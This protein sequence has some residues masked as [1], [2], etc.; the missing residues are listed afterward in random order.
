M[1][2]KFLFIGIIICFLIFIKNAHATTISDCSNLAT[3]GSTYTLTS[4]VSNVG[5]GVCMN[6]TNSNIILD[7]A[8]NYIY[9]QQGGGSSYGINIS[10]STTNDTVM[11]CNVTNWAYGVFISSSTN[12]TNITLN[13]FKN[14]NASGSGTG[15]RMGGSSLFGNNFTNNTFIN[16]GRGIDIETASTNNYYNNT[17]LNNTYAVY[18]ASSSNNGNFFNNT[19]AYNNVSFY[20]VVPGPFTFAYNTFTEL[21]NYPFGQTALYIGQPSDT[22]TNYKQIMNETNVINGLPILFRGSNQNPCINN[23]VWTNGSSYGYMGFVGCNNITVTSTS[24]LDG[25]FFA[26]VY[27]SVISNVNISY[28]YEPIELYATNNTTVS[29]GIFDFNA[30]PGIFIYNYNNNTNVINSDISHNNNSGVIIQSTASVGYTQYNLSF[31]NNTINDNSWNNAAGVYINN[32][33]SNITLLNNTINFNSYSFGS[34]G[35][36]GGIYS[37]ATS[38]QIYAYNNT[39]YT[40]TFGVQL[41]SSALPWFNLTGG[42]IFSSLFADYYLNNQGNAN[43]FTNTNFTSNRTIKLQTI[44]DQFNYANDTS[45][46]WMGTNNIANH[47]L[48]RS[49]NNWNYTNMTWSDWD[50][51]T[52]TAN[53]T[54]KGLLT[55]ALYNVSNFSMSYYTL[56]TN[57]SG[58][59][60]FSI[61]LNSTSRLIS[62]F[63][64]T[65]T[66]PPTYSNNNTNLKSAGYNITHNLTFADNVGISG[67]IF[68]FDNGTGTMVNDSWVNTNNLTS[69]IAS[70]T[71]LVTST[72]GA[73]VQ[74]CYYANDTS[75]N[76]NR[77]SCNN[78]FTYITDSS[79]AVYQ[80]TQ[81]STNNTVYMLGNSFTNLTT[82]IACMNITAFNATLNC[83]GYNINGTTG[84]TTYGIYANWTSSTKQNITVQNCNVSNWYYNIYG[85]YSNNDTIANN[86][87]LGNGAGGDIVLTSCSNTRITNNTAIGDSNGAGIE[88]SNGGSSNNYVLNNTFSSDE[89]GVYLISV[90]SGANNSFINDSVYSS[91]SYDYYLN[92]AGAANNFTNTNFT[93]SAPRVI[94]LVQTSD[95]FNYAND[96]SGLWLETNN[97]AS[98]TF[99]RNLIYWSN[100]FISWNETDTGTDTAN[101][102]LIGL[103]PNTNY[104]VY[105][106]TGFIF[107][108][109]SLSYT[110]NSGP[111]GTINFTIPLTTTR[112]TIQVGETAVSQCANIFQNNSAYYLTSSFT[113]TTAAYCLNITGFNDTIDCQ[114][115]TITGS[116][117]NNGI[118]EYWP[119]GAHYQNNTIKNCNVNTWSFGFS[120]NYA[121]NTTLINNTANFNAGHAF[122]CSNGN[123]NTYINNTANYNSASGYGMDFT[124]SPNNT[125]INNTASGEGWGITFTLSSSNNEILINNTIC[126][127]TSIGLWLWSG[128]NISVT[129]GSIFNNTLDY[130]MQS[131][132]NTNI[133]NTN[134]T[135]QRSIKFSATTDYF[136][137]ANDTSSLRLNTSNINAHTLNRTLYSWSQIN[138]SWNDTDSGTDAAANYT[139]YG[140]MPNA[141][142]GVYNFSILY[143]TI[144]ASSLGMINFN[145]SLNTTP[146][147]IQVN[148]TTPQ[149]TY[150]FNSTNSTLA[151]TPIN[152]SLYWNSSYGL[153]GYIFQFCNGTWNGTNCLSNSCQYNMTLNDTNNGNVG[154]A[155][156]DPSNPNYN[157]GKATSLGV[158]VFPRF[159][160][161]L[162]NLSGI[163]AGAIITNAN[164]SITAANGGNAN[165]GLAVY[166]TSLYNAS[167]NG[168]W[169]EGTLNGVSCGSMCDLTQNI[170]MNNQP[171]NTMTLQYN[172]TVVNIIAGSVEWLNVTNSTIV[173]FANATN[174]NMSLAINYTGAGGWSFYS[175]EW[176]TA[177]QRPQ[178]VVTYY[179]P[180]ICGWVND[181]WKSMTGTGNWSNVTKIVNS[182][183]GAN[184]AWCEY[185]NNTYNVW[186]STSCNV[187]SGVSPF[188]YTTTSVTIFTCGTPANN[189]P[190][191]TQTINYNALQQQIQ[192]IMRLSFQSI[193]LRTLLQRMGM[194]FRNIINILNFN[195]IAQ[196]VGIVIKTITQQIN[197]NTMIYSLRTAVE[198]ISQSISLNSMVNKIYSTARNA[199]QQ[200]TF[201]A[202][203]MRVAAAV[204]VKNAFQSININS[205]ASRAYTAFIKIPQIL[206]INTALSKMLNL[207]RNIGQSIN[208]NTMISKFRILTATVYGT[209]TQSINFNTMVGK[210][211]TAVRNVGQPITFGAF[212]QKTGGKAASPSQSITFNTMVNRLVYEMKNVGQAITFNTMVSRFR[213]LSAS[214]YGTIT[215]SIK[216]NTM[217]QRVLIGIRN[218]GQAI[219]FNTMVRY[220]VY[221]VRNGAQSI[222]LNTMVNRLVYEMKNVGQSLTFSTMMNRMLV[223][224]RNIPQSIMFNTMVNRLVYEIRNA[225]QSIKFSTM[226]GRLRT[227]FEYG[228]QS[229]MFNSMASRMLYA[230][231]NAG[232]SITFNTMVS[233]FRI[234]SASV[235][236]TISQ[237]ITFNTMAGRVRT[238]FRYAS[239]NIIF[240]TMMKYGLSAVRNVGQPITFGAFGGKAGGKTTS[241]SQSLTFNTMVNR[242]SF[243]FKY[244]PQSLTFNT[245]VNRFRILSTST[246]GG[247]SQRININTMVNRFRN[248]LTYASQSIKLN[249]MVNKLLMAV[250]NGAQSITF[251]TM[252]NRLSAESRNVG[253]AINFNT[254]AKRVLS[255]FRYV[256]Q[257]ITFNTMMSR[258]RILLA[259]NYG[260]IAQSIKINTMVGRL[261][262]TFGLA[263]QSITFNSMVSRMLSMGRNV[264]Q[265]ITFFSLGQKILPRLV[266]ATQQI[267]INT[268]V[269]RVLMGV[270]IGGQSI[271]FNTMFGTFFKYIRIATQQI[272]FATMIKR[273]LLSIIN[274]PQSITFNTMV[275]RLRTAVI[276]VFQPITFQTITTKVLSASRTPTQTI[277][278][279]TMVNKALIGIRSA[280]QSL[281]FNTMAQRVRTAIRNGYQSITFQTMLNMPNGPWGP[282]GPGPPIFTG[283]RFPFQAINFNEMV[284]RILIMVGKVLH[285]LGMT[286]ANFEVSEHGTVYALLKDASGQPVTRANCSID[287]LNPDLTVWNFDSMTEFVNGTYYYNFTAPNV[288]GV[289]EVGVNCTYNTNT[290]Y[291]VSYF[292]VVPFAQSAT[293][294]LSMTDIMGVDVTNLESLV[295]NIPLIGSSITSLNDSFISFGFAF[296][297]AFT[298]GISVLCA[299]GFAIITVILFGFDRIKRLKHEEEEGEEEKSAGYF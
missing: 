123:S 162:F 296:N 248:V 264:A 29:N 246:L 192:N 7:C 17:F 104:N 154:D 82:N 61:A 173:T 262:T 135:G 155:W 172:L 297:Q 157:Y 62:L 108:A 54:I 290:M 210:L 161:L 65:D 149:L 294:I 263:S 14:M 6:F 272:N 58:V 46:L 131:A 214:V 32:Y 283:H 200:I 202:N 31:V 81:I 292:H 226:I 215:Q 257:S 238:A 107:N 86:T 40:N 85:Y 186:N 281:T 174:K 28:T 116:V 242:L 106:S 48:N 280:G 212:G 166:N 83:Q 209:I 10:Q 11:R 129:G 138:M 261:R 258:F 170:T 244:F 293:K 73:T 21:H 254:M 146:Q 291:D 111:A 284:M 37:Q 113:N 230:G 33:M 4:N 56:I 70:T 34:Q 218:A 49:L 298:V 219:N 125:L 112:Q 194:L 36:Y 41:T 55:F 198:M 250:R 299:I 232:Q 265:S 105:N 42:S 98:S 139:I 134:F 142:Y 89:Y 235:Y 196:R 78:P 236:G 19:F 289:Y 201:Y 288:E 20:L 119:S 18:S 188:N 140:L 92:S 132:T 241:P 182:T 38:G 153:S 193:N 109:S 30:Q 216:F 148:T 266:S 114:G 222:K 80:C 130:T 275:G 225:G 211:L 191:A 69:I 90:G 183:V 167:G 187:V 176:S 53:Y 253:Q 228:Y 164:L 87:I 63:N 9:G 255:A 185:A 180:G 51:S 237:S 68:S 245:M 249:T 12:L 208:F 60:N 177:S 35:D 8:N 141:K 95:Y 156:T 67:Y 287:I 74:W 72:V 282:P 1:V 243:N 126:N 100:A 181:T 91:T 268:M 203:G 143:W 213:I 270:R 77:T 27:N 102:T 277:Y 224:I 163:P 231:R 273:M 103:V 16:E 217:A 278:F 204:T 96:N 44:S 206:N 124:S 99:T 88:F 234:L 26:G 84:A 251:N 71:K 5:T 122:D 25:I 271:T 178:L 76:W 267:N 57:L 145:I 184:V 128:Q 94:R 179:A 152:H 168:P 45:G 207:V 240:N 50:S 274:A 165:M 79:M 75:N 279:N 120:L 197:I 285:S 59:L 158:N 205:F 229:M 97:I 144:N 64:I 223:G 195:N 220:G 110:L 189:C 160:W 227:N 23:T 133:T 127:T 15:I 171:N 121:S 233:R 101:Y 260:V 252:V 117:S 24:P 239:Q 151:G 47:V 159:M 93:A 199:Q 43:N 256:T 147:I 295:K 39:L 136:N 175:K 169:V 2:K 13:I 3:S 276:S 137:Y 66:L 52:D 259:T 247:V 286:V 115:Y 190:N 269:S 221:A 118:A 22:V 150:F